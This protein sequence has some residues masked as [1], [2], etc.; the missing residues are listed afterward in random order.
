MKEVLET[1][2]DRND[3][4]PEKMEVQKR[5][6]SRNDQDKNDKRRSEGR[7]MVRLKGNR[8]C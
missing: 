3:G 2:K 7:G 1:L 6:R 8:V 5:R 4:G